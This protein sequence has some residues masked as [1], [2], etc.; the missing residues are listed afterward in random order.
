MS[1]ESEIE[2]K[3]LLRDFQRKK[4][5]KF[6]ESVLEKHPLNQVLTLEECTTLARKH[7]PSVLVKD[8]R[9]RRHAGA[10]FEDNLITL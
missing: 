8:G 9:G 3:P 10:S 4:L 2:L 1:M 6:E 7:N 5:Y